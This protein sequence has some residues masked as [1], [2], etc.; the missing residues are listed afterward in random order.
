MELTADDTA[1]VDRL[2]KM[3]DV[4]CNPDVQ[5]HLKRETLPRLSMAIQPQ[6]LR[7]ELKHAF[8][9]QAIS[10]GVVD[11]AVHLVSLD[12]ST[13]G[14][15]CDFLGDFAFYSDTASRAVVKTFNQIV[16]H[17][18]PQRLMQIRP[19]ISL[20]ANIVATC[21]AEHQHIVALVGPVFLP[22]INDP[23]TTDALMSSTIL[24]LANLSLTV[25]HELRGLGVVDALLALVTDP[26]IPDARKS[27]AESVIIL[28][29]GDEG[30]CEVDQLIERNVIKDYCLPILESALTGSSFRGMYPHLVYSIQLFDVL[31]RSRRYAE[32]ITQHQE[33]VPLLLRASQHCDN[34][35]WLQSDNE[36]RRL[37][38]RC[39]RRQVSFGL[40]PGPGDA[41]SADSASNSTT[42]PAN[43]A[44][45]QPFI[46]KSLPLILSDDDVR[47]RSAAASLWAALN[48]EWLRLMQ[49][50]GRRLEAEGRLP[51]PL[52]Q[53]FLFALVP[54]LAVGD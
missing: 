15:V 31:L 7:I 49:L 39:L 26:F 40:W 18:V 35:A 28:V 10:K 41:E 20:C 21:P 23:H 24:L 45:S 13:A 17:F 54:E 47:V 9:L 27:V 2:L 19:F 5:L 51:W 32:T 52:W 37:A 1:E 3:V 53:Q 16:H 6:Q 43:A 48:P 4:I 36:G 34:L 46:T 8:V 11:A 29:R 30:G 42:T 25:S 12:K 14:V 22:I 44:A 33:A 50:V 38:L